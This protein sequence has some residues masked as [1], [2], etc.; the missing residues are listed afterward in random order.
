LLAVSKGAL[1]FAFGRVGEQP[2]RLAPLL[3]RFVVAVCVVYLQVDVLEEQ[4]RF[5]QAPQPPGN[6]VRDQSTSGIGRGEADR[7]EGYGLAEAFD[8]LDEQRPLVEASVAHPLYLVDEPIF[9]SRA[10]SHGFPNNPTWV[11]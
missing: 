2:H 1:E 11:G 4:A 10:R 7:L 3:I 8:Y 5:S 6:G 9:C